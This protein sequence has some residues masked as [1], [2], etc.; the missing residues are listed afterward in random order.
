MQLTKQKEISPDRKKCNITQQN[1]IHPDSFDAQFIA[2]L[3]E[4]GYSYEKTTIA[5]NMKKN[6]NAITFCYLQCRLRRCK[7]TQS[8]ET[9]GEETEAGFLQPRGKMF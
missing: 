1:M 3:I 7:E 4:S 5:L 9:Y 6:R 8:P 2:N